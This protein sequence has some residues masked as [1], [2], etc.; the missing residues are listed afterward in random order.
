MPIR[1]YTVAGYSS[2]GSFWT[3]SWPKKGTSKLL[4]PGQKT[5][6]DDNEDIL[7]IVPLTDTLRD[8]LKLRGVMRGVTVFMIVS[9]EFADGTVYNNK[10]TKEAL[11]AY[12]NIVSSKVP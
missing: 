7:E 3:K 8:Q 12:F 9:V 10:P 5:S 6:A 2:Y 4:M 11:E 1:D